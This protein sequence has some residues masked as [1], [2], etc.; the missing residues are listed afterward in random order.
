MTTSDGVNIAYLCVGEGTPI[1]FAS[2]FGGDV[3]N[4]HAPITNVRGTTDSLVRLGYRVIRHDTRGMGA[5]D[6]DISDWSLDARV[7]DLDAVV[8][9]L[10]VRRFALVG[11]DH[12]APTAITYAARHPDRVSHLALVCPW[13]TGA[14]QYALPAV[15]FAS[16][17]P[18]DDAEWKVFANVVGS[19]VTEFTDLN[20]SRAV[21]GSLQRT[22]TA[23]GLAAYHRA[24]AAIDVRE[25]LPRVM[26]PTV[27][28]HEPTFPFGS[29]EL[30]H[31][32][33]AGIPNARLVVVHERSMIGEAFDE[34][35]ATLDR[36]LRSGDAP[37][38]AAEPS[39][40]STASGGLTPR[41]R[42]VLRLIAAGRSNKVIA[43][44]L[45]MS[46][47]TVARHIT[48]LYAK[49]DVQSKAAATAYAIRH[50]LT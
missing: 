23:E 1:V 16:A 13:A 19:V 8:S 39:R 33:A 44:D 37:N 36:F 9:H 35:V 40:P 14:G 5:S 41:E 50:G 2:N 21:A 17:P 42:E 31:E 25:L 29:L 27:I 15:R 28:L 7:R 47:R 26:A 11:M 12:G 34:T 48:N 6:R 10:D 49:I 38:G 43:F 46:E 22:V 4:Y 45:R 20:R 32:V 24:G 18:S 30:C 3:H